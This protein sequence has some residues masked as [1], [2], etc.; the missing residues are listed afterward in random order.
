MV[1]FNGLRL[2]LTE[3]SLNIRSGNIRQNFSFLKIR[4]L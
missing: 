4:V 2:I 1:K 3:L